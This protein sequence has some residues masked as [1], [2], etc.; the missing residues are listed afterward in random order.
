MSHLRRLL[1]YYDRFKITCTRI[2][3]PCRFDDI[4]PHNIADA[5]A[6]SLRVTV[7]TVLLNHRIFIKLARVFLIV[8]TPV[9][10]NIVFALLVHACSCISHSI[11]PTNS[12]DHV[13][14]NRDSSIALEFIRTRGRAWQSH[15]RR[16]RLL[17]IQSS[18]IIR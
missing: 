14:C 11:V 2:A 18:R 17:I 12:Y 10:L 5:F 3:C 4:E 1:S 7:S 15:C 8:V 13:S 9:K 16:L 6:R